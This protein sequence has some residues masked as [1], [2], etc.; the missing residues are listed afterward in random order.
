MNN[1]YWEIKN[2][3]KSD[4]GKTVISVALKDA[5]NNSYEVTFKWDGCIDFWKYCNG[6]TPED[7]MTEEE[8]ENSVDYIH[9]CDIDEMITRLTELKKIMGEYNVK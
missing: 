3:N 2:V 4:D 1:E 6:F 9:I 8:Y 7:K 5:I